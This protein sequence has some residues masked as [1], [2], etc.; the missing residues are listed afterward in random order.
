ML[1]RPSAD[2]K[3]ASVRRGKELLDVDHEMAELPLSHQVGLQEEYAA[4]APHVVEL[5]V[6]DGVSKAE[7]KECGSRMAQAGK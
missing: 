2:K 3:V 5:H 4:G 1:M 7:M 6:S